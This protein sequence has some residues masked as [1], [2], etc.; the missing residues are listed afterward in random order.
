MENSR[1]MRIKAIVSGNSTSRS[2]RLTAASSQDRAAASCFFCERVA[3]AEPSNSLADRMP[4]MLGR[5]EHLRGLRNHLKRIGLRLFPLQGQDGILNA[6]VNHLLRAAQRAGKQW[7]GLTPFP[8]R[9]G[10]AFP[11][12][13]T[14]LQK[15]PLRGAQLLLNNPLQRPCQLA[16]RL[17]MVL[18]L[19]GEKRLLDPALIGEKIP[20]IL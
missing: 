17:P 20:A 11:L 1:A 5:G 14:A 12:Q 9:P 7:S 18:F 13:P 16:N 2:H 10:R 6:A 8:A 15:L 19:R 4:L 3:R